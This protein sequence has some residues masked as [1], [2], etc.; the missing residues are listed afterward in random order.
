MITEFRTF[1]E[2]YLSLVR[3]LAS[4]KESSR[5]AFVQLQDA[6]GTEGT[7]HLLRSPKLEPDLRLHALYAFAWFTRPSTVALRAAWE[8]CRA[9]KEDKE[10]RGGFLSKLGGWGFASHHAL[11]LWFFVL[12]DEEEDISSLAADEILQ[13][14][15]KLTKGHVRALRTPDPKVRLSAL[16]RLVKI[17]PDLLEML[18]S[19]R[20]AMEGKEPLSLTSESEEVGMEADDEGAL[21]E[22]REGNARDSSALTDCSNETRPRWDNSQQVGLQFGSTEELDAAIDWLWTDAILRDLPRVHVGRNTMIVPADTVDLFRNKGYHFTLSRV[23]SAGDLP[24][25]D[26]NRIRREGRFRTI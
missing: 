8:I 26:I 12:Q 18:D 9:G 20:L 13:I 24:P 17:Q 14:L 7:L 10:W 1:Y 11:P 25:E 21:K 2:L 15:P 19:L 3:T 23:V 5:E 22:D 6:L 16:Q 4:E